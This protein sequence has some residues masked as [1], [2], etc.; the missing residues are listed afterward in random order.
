MR[1]SLHLVL[2][3]ALLSLASVAQAEPSR[4]RVIQLNPVKVS[5]RIQT[6]LATV[7]I[8]RIQPKLTL[9]ELRPT[10]ANRIG[11]ATAR[12]PY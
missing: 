3:I 6:P 4:G 10:F 8:N 1:T 12:D 7:E 9:P 2:G 5:G 11:T